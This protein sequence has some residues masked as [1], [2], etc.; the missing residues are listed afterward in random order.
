MIN[1]GFTDIESL[2]YGKMF[3]ELMCLWVVLSGTFNTLVSSFSAIFLTE[4]FLTSRHG[5]TK[6]YSLVF[7]F[8]AKLFEV[9]SI[10][11]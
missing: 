8:Y 10:C 1:A 6:E 2:V 5:H 4:F 9:Q 7:I 3:Y 11:W